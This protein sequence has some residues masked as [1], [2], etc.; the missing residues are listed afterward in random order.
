MVLDEGHKKINKLQF[1]EQSLL[2]PV[3]TTLGGSVQGTRK[4]ISPL[5]TFVFGQH[6]GEYKPSSTNFQRIGP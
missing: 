6:G 2:D 4:Y 5:L 1:V 3:W